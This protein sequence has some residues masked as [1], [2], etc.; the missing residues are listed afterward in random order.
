[1]ARGKKLSVGERTMIVNA[2]KF[3]IKGRKEAK[4]LV[5]RT[6]KLVHN[7][8][9]MPPSTVGDAWQAYKASKVAE[10]AEAS[11]REIY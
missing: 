2:S 1:M 6:R 10:S 3:F 5:G 4:T 9:G 7:C 11:V 8:L